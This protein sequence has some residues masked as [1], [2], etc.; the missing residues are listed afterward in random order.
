MS[1]EKS[2]NRGKVAVPAEAVRASRPRVLLKA[3]LAQGA[4]NAKT[5]RRSNTKKYHFSLT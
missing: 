1:K 2:L 4:K 5:Q 3:G